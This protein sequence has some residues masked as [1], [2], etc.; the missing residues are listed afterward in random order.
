MLLIP[1]NI[2]HS[3]SEREGIIREVEFTILKMIFLS[4]EK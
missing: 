2:N 3:L 4:M 1:V